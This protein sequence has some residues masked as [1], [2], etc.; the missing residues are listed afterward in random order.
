MA[1]IPDTN[2]NLTNNIG[3]VL[4]DAGGNVNINYAP[5]FLRRMQILENGRSISRS[6]T[7][8]L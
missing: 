5:S 3:A 1:I 6:N 4:R 8:K 2:I 7:R